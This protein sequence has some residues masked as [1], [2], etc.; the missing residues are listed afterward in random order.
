MHEVTEKGLK[1]YRFE[2]LNDFAEIRHGVLTRQGGSSAL[3]F[4]G[5]N[6]AFGVGDDPAHGHFNRR[7]ILKAVGGTQMK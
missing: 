6:V 1:F 5:L 4:D 2:Q 7:S 3:P